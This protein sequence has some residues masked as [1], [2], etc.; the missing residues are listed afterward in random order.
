MTGL[1]VGRRGERGARQEDRVGLADRSQIRDLLGEPS[2]FVAHDEPL[3]EVRAVGE[4]LELVAAEGG[5]ARELLAGGEVA[6]HRRLRR[7]ERHR[8][9]DVT[10]AAPRVRRLLVGVEIALELGDLPI[11]EEVDRDRSMRPEEQDALG[12]LDRRELVGLAGQL[13]PL[14]ARLGKMRFPEV[15]REQRGRQRLRVVILACDVE[16]FGDE[17]ALTVVVGVV[18]VGGDPGEH[19]HEALA[20]GGIDAGPRFFEQV[21]R[22]GLEDGAIGPRPVGYQCHVG[23]QCRAA[24][25]PR[26]RGRG[27]QRVTGRLDLLVVRSGTSERELQPAPL[28]LVALVGAELDGVFIPTGRFAEYEPLGGVIGGALGISGR[29]VLQTERRGFDVVMRD[30]G[31]PPPRRAVGDLLFHHLG[32]PAVQMPANVGR[33]GG[34]DRIANHRVEQVPVDLVVVLDEQARRQPLLQ[35]L[36]RD[37]RRELTDRGERVDGQLAPDRGRGADDAA[38]VLGQASE[39]AIDERPNARG[40]DRGDRLAELGRALDLHVL[41]VEL[42]Q[43]LPQEKRIAT[44]DVVQG[45]RELDEGMHGLRR[46]RRA[47]ERAHLVVVESRQV[48]L[49]ALRG[50]RSRSMSSARSASISSR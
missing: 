40:R 21:E 28:R 4:L 43:E 6:V 48:D 26:T 42:A 45:N 16:R 13:E 33:N 47:H 27:E 3:Q 10:R 2:L 31:T 18:D 50:T 15:Y 32:D 39:A 25:P 22:V 38:S 5:A 36:E 49:R 23:E 44:R 41:F 9:V 34:V 29:L 24:A 20:I 1:G 14:T 8:R 37:A 19:A 11:L 12:G 35:R 17:P 7:P 46:R 30:I